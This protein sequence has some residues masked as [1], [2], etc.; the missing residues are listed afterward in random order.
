MR[1][2]PLPYLMAEVR[3]AQGNVIP[4]FERDKFVIWDGVSSPTRDTQVDT[5]DMPLRWNG[6][7]A[8]QLAGQNIRLRFYFGG[9]TVYAVT[10]TP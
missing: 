5:T 8:R 1:G 9:S 7:S 2:S 4:G 3:D 10:A 6:V